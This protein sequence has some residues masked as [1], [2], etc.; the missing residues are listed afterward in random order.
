MKIELLQISKFTSTHINILT[1]YRSRN[2]NLANLNDE[3]GTMMQPDKP[4]LL[5]GDFN[6]CQ[7]ELSTNPTK[8]FL[9]QNNFM[10]L[11]DK[12]THIAGNVLDQ[13]HLHDI[14][15][16]LTAAATLHSKYYTD[17]KGIAVI[18]KKRT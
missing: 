17:H 12:P 8:K 13:A 2:G 7:A 18:I 5:I 16:T 11:I 1:I 6:Y 10:N 14:E 4:L 15:R 3:I 9:T